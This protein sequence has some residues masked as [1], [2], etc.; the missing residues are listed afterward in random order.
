MKDEAKQSRFLIKDPDDG[1]F[2]NARL[3]LLRLHGRDSS[4]T[5]HTHTHAD[6][7]THNSAGVLTTTN[8]PGV[9]KI[10]VLPVTSSKWAFPTLSD[11]RGYNM[12]RIL[13]E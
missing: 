6:P 10:E 5:H 3:A 4:V 1:R 7:R 11:L 8:A 9:L 2:E 12:Q 13:M